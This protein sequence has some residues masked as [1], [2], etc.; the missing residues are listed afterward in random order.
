MGLSPPQI[1][2]AELLAKNHSQQEV[3]DAV[4]VSRRTILRWLKQPDFKNLSFGLVSRVA[5]SPQQLPQPV[6][7]S[8]KHRQSN[9]LTPQDLVEDALSAIRDILQD[10]DSRNCD[11]IKVAALV[12]EWAGLS[13]KK[14]Q[15]TEMEAIKV[16]IEANW[17]SD[18]VLEVLINA[19][20]ELEEKMKNALAQNHQNA[21]ENSH[22]KAL[23]HKFEEGSH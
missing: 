17:L 7:S 15:M 16:L 14:S 21:H 23:L 22:K 3:A 20:V 18:E 5:Q 2:A 13:Q 19:G 10:P 12:G 1:R 11:R 6:Y 9:S 8:E 4:G